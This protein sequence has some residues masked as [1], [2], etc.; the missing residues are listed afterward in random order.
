MVSLQM[1]EQIETKKYILSFSENGVTAKLKPHSKKEK[2]ITVISSFLICSIS[3]AVFA[4]AVVLF[5]NRGYFYAVTFILMSVALA[6]CNIY[7]TMLKEKRIKKF[8][9]ELS[10]QGITH[11][12]AKS[13][14]FISWEEVASFGLVNHIAIFRTDN[15]NP[16]NNQTCLYFSKKVHDEK[17]LRK[18]FDRSQFK[19][20]KHSST[21][22]I[23]VFGFLEDDLPVEL[24]EKILKFIYSFCEKEKEKSFFKCAYWNLVEEQDS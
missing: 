19:M 10:A 22:E 1:I 5:I 21:N 20:H 17:Y 8:S 13:M 9:F 3:L 24:T 11:I 15:W 14:Y 23:I 7:V 18:K 16:S 2:A 6:W 12:D 4:L